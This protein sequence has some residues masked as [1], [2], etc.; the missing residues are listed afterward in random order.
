M[1]QHGSHNITLFYKSLSV[2]GQFYVTNWQALGFN[3][4]LFAK[5]CMM[6]IRTFYCFGGIN[7]DLLNQ[8]EKEK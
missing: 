1:S 6:L 4:S 3:I 8:V 2:C 5:N 7:P